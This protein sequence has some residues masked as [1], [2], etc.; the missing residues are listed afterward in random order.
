MPSRQTD[1]D[2]DRRIADRSRR[3]FLLGVGATAV[4]AGCLGDDGD[5]DDETT[6]PNDETATPEPSDETA[7]PEP[8]DETATPEPDDGSGGSLSQSEARDL[9]PLESLAFRY[10]PPLGSQF[11][12]FWVAVVREADA[13]AVRAEAESGGYNEVTPQDGTID[14]YLGVPV[15]VD[16]DGD[17]VTV[18]AVDEDGTRGPVTEITVPTDELTTAQ[19]EQAVPP[20]ALSFT[21]EPPNAGDYGS[22]IIEV[23]ADTGADTLVAQ[24]QEAPGLFTDRV[25]NLGDEERIGAGTTLDVAV[26]PEGDEVILWASVDGATGEVTRW[27]G[28]D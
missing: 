7:T 6:E 12:E 4:L 9:L 14:R 13:T 5:S 23:T 22:L 26:D 2:H 24:P 17:E 10:E 19:A 1:S 25:G 18:F 28:P 21:Y 20:D 27:Q 3:K 8:D 15:Q 11:G 16:P